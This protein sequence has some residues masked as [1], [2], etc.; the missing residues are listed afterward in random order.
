M[1]QDQDL[2]GLPCSSRRDS[3]SPGVSRMVKRNKN[4]RH[5]IG[6]HHGRSSGEQIC[7]SGPWVKFSAHAA[8]QVLRTAEATGLS[9]LTSSSV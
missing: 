6:D 2:C 9:P 8:G 4:R 3:R 1:A 7:W 5:M